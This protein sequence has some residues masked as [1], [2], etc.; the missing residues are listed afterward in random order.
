MGWS[1]LSSLP[2]S[3]PGPPMKVMQLHNK[4]QMRWHL[5]G[6]ACMRAAAGHGASLQRH[7]MRRQP[8]T[9]PFQGFHH[10]TAQATAGDTGGKEASQQLG[11]MLAGGRARPGRNA[12]P[13]GGRRQQKS[14]VTERK[15][16]ALAL[17]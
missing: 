10:G 5:P 11:S 14:K 7:C 12:Q 8:Q 1:V 15:T 13:A 16:F 2:T 4:H 3:L 6:R 17:R 9:L